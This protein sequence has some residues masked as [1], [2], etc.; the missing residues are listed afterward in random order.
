MN[1]LEKYCA[2]HYI[3]DHGVISNKSPIMSLKN[4]LG[5]LAYAAIAVGALAGAVLLADA[6]GPVLSA[7][8]ATDPTRLFC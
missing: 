5:A 2:V 8:L 7:P 3:N 1:R 4:M 6:L